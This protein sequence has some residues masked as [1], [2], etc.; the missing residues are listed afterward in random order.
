MVFVVA[1]VVVDGVR[2]CSA[3]GTTLLYVSLRLVCGGDVKTAP[4]ELSNTAEVG[5][6]EDVVAASGFS[7]A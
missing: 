4:G 1:D 7:N 6:V 2:G 3:S 5:S